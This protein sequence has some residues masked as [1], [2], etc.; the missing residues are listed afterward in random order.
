MYCSGT[1][2]HHPMPA[3][4]QAHYFVTIF[5]LLYIHVDHDV[6]ISSARMRQKVPVLVLCVCLSVC[7]CVCVCPPEL[8][9][10]RTGASKRLTKGTS[11]LSGT[12]FTQK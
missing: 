2:I 11:G 7:L 10:L 6:N 12:F 8:L 9:N 4:S 5:L 1:A 3:N